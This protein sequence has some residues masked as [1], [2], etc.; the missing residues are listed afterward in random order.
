MKDNPVAEMH[1]KVAISSDFLSAFSRIPR[2]LQNKVMN[3]IDKFRECPTSPGINYEKIVMAKDRNLRSVRIDDT[4]R[5]I[6]LSPES[7][8]V[9]VLLWVDHHDAA[10]AW[11][12]RRLCAIHPETG[13]L[14]V[15]DV[16]KTVVMTEERASPQPEASMGMFAGIRDRQLISLGVPDSLFALVRS[17][18]SEDELDAVSDRMPEEIYEILLMLAAGYTVEQASQEMTM[19]TEAKVID[20]EDFSSALENQESQRRF[21]VV[22]DEMEL[23]AILSAPLEK[24]RVFLHPSQRQL[25]NREWNG[26]VRVLGGAGTGKTV[27]AL[28]RAKWLAENH[29][30]EGLKRVLFTTF[31]RN[32]AADIKENLRKIC[33]EGTFAKIEVT[34]LDR[35]VADFLRKQGYSLEIDYGKRTQPLWKKALTMASPEL[36]FRPSFYR[37]EWERVI[38]PQGIATLSDYFKASRIGRGTLLNRK[39]RKE[40]W[41]V[42]QEYRLLLDENGLREPDDAMRD[43]CQIL[44]QKR[45]DLPYCAVVVDEAQDMGCQAFRLIRQMIPGDGNKND[46]FM[47]GDGHQRIYRHKV[48]VGRCGVNIRG[49]SRKLRINYRTT[50]ENRRW[51]VKL[52][53]NTAV[54]DLDGGSDDQQGYKSL[55]HGEAPVMRNF[56]SSREESEYITAMV[57]ECATQSQNLNSICIVA[58]NKDLLEQYQSDLESL[59]IPTYTIR[60]NEAENRTA[61]GIRLATIHRIK[62]LEFDTVII[63]AVND[64]ILPWEQ[65]IPETDDSV[66]RKESENQERALLYVAATRAKRRVIVTSYGRQSCF[67]GGQQ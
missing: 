61:P 19:A 48:A 2:K 47:V 1:I 58:R 42:F 39:S 29:C 17:I 13:S 67:L 64:K 55:L 14:Q 44:E 60:R 26:P 43:A 15:I 27:V 12:I 63:A 28:H 50:E 5:A 9:Y 23:K 22:G 52:L 38:Q 53:E 32:L 37:E 7:G 66:V 3:F 62:G 59:N 11:A 51:A 8:N 18:N 21:Y 16:E 20:P 31:T 25:V 54:D 34:N 35:W 45:H 41:N 65:P 10:Y 49:R 24:W 46:I 30:K 4:Y 6:V 36:G 33:N 57:R 40:V 56:A